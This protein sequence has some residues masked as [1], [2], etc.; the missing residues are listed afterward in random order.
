MEEK[1]E[2]TPD[3]L[4]VLQEQQIKAQQELQEK[5][6]RAGK[7]INAILDREGLT[8]IANQVVQLVPRK[9]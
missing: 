1:K 3:E 6:D 7:E 4:K 8:L 9:R 2:I 5:L